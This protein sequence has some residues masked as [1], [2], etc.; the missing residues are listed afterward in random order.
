MVS[1]GCRSE[2][3]ATLVPGG[4]R[5]VLERLDDQNHESLQLGGVRS[6][7]RHAATEIVLVDARNAVIGRVRFRICNDCRTGRILD[8]WVLDTW[9]RQGLGRELVNTLLAHCTGLGWSTTRQT[10]EGRLFF[11]AMTQETS[12]HF[13][14]CGAL[15]VH[16]TGRFTRVWRRLIS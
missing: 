14:Q 3:G 10:P 4:G 12:I 8:V 11:S 16:L 7:D 1:L 5:A 9:Q 2:D 13:P 15:C 6:P